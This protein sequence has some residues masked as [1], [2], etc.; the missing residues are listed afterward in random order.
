MDENHS[1]AVI[2]TFDLT[3]AEYPIVCEAVSSLIASLYALSESV[4]RSAQWHPSE[5]RQAIRRVV[6]IKDTAFQE[7][8]ARTLT[9]DRADLPF[10]RLAVEQWLEAVVVR[11]EGTKAATHLTEPDSILEKQ[12]R[13]AENILDRNDICRAKSAPRYTLNQY[14]NLEAVAK[15]QGA[16]GALPERRFD[17]K[18]HILTAQ[19]LFMPDLRYFRTQCEMRSRPVSVAYIDIDDFKAFN[20]NVSGGET[21][22]DRV[23][24]PKF[25][26][27]LEAFVFGRGYAYREGGD[28]YLV[29]LPGA[30]YAEARQFFLGLRSHLA[31]V[32]Y[33]GLR[34]LKPPT[35]SIGVCTVEAGE[36]LTPLQIQKLANMAKS[37]AKELGGK[38]CVA[39]FKEGSARENASL[40]VFPDGTR[41]TPPAAP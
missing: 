30:S 33:D 32:G 9:I 34:D 22:V 38:D 13:A 25:M 5:L 40:C 6:G 37:H 3:E 12:R 16:E 35:V 31:A 26:S 7:P 20:K 11:H 24:L 8:R 29:L 41:L 27:A 2:L 10:L 4:D 18:F 14:L 28:E 1:R 21:M 23:L 17:D 15:A 36:R 19:S 39:G